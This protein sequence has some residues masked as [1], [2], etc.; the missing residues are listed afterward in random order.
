MTM[1]LAGELPGAVQR[2][3]RGACYSLF[4]ALL[5]LCAAGQSCVKL[6]DVASGVML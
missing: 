2:T 1:Y 4:A 6:S 3:G 5:M